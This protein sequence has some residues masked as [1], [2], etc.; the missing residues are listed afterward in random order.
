MTSIQIRDVSSELS[1]ALKS[2]A[3]QGEMSLSDYVRDELER[4]VER[5]ST[6]ELRE[7]LGRHDVAGL[8]SVA[9]VLRRARARR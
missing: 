9:D 1:D 7:R 4:L 8:P 6:A 2:R 3:A 5:P